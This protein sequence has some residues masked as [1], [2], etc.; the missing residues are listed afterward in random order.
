MLFSRSFMGEGSEFPVPAPQA[1]HMPFYM[2]FAL[3]YI[4][5]SGKSCRL[6]RCKLL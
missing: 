3:L 2:P 6:L 4:E 5:K 1:A